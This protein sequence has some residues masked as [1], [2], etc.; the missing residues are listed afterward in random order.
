MYSCET[1]GVD[2]FESCFFPCPNGGRLEKSYPDPRVT[3]PIVRAECKRDVDTRDG[4]IREWFK[5]GGDLRVIGQYKN[6]KRDGKWVIWSKPGVGGESTRET[7]CQYTNG[8]GR[9]VNGTGI[10]G[11]CQN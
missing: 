2:S 8:K 5:D 10:D 11:L 9:M 3:A 4:P 1:D 7:Q 6:G